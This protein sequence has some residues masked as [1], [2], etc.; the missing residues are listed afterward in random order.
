MS[1]DLKGALRQLLKRRRRDVVGGGDT[2][3]LAHHG[4]QGN[5]GVGLV[6]ILVDGVVGKAREAVVLTE[7][8]CFGLIGLRC[9]QR[10]FG[11]REHLIAVSHGYALLPA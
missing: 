7:H 2:D 8:D 1:R 3:S 5:S 6:D 9:G 11:Y 10:L 4:A